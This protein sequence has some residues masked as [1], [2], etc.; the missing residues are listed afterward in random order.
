[1]TGVELRE[2]VRSRLE[3]EHRL[4]R[5]REHVRGGTAPGTAADDAEV[6][7]CER[8]IPEDVFPTCHQQAFSNEPVAVTMN[9]TPRSASADSGFGPSIS[10]GLGVDSGWSGRSCELF[11]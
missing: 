11:S 9:C 3:D 7:A 2:R 5:R 1:P 6:E 4:A 8:G 10:S